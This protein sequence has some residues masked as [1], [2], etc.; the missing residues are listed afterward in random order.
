MTA[1][2]VTQVLFFGFLIL[3]SLRSNAGKH[4][5]AELR[6]QIV[7][8]VVEILIDHGMP[9]K[10]DR[11][12]PWFRHSF[13]PNSYVIYLYQEDQIPIE[14]K[15]DIIRYCMLLHENRRRRDE[16][17]ILMFREKFE[18]KLFQAK[19]SFELILR[20]ER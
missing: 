18:P 3:A 6:S 13:V 15:V 9:I 4:P 8:D 14:A 16:F 7:E 11:E 12:D 19:P 17:K 20:G 1:K 10:R 2:G 5:Y